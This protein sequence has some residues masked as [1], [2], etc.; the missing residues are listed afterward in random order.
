M[1]STTLPPLP[2]LPVQCAYCRKVFTAGGDMA[3]GATVPTHMAA[4]PD[5]AWCKTDDIVK[6]L[7]KP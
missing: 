3:C 4:G 5:G 1:T 6:M 2:P 7:E